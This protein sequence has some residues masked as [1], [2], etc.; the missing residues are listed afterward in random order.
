MCFSPK[1]M[2]FCYRILAPKVLGV[3]TKTRLESRMKKFK[4][5]AI[6]DCL[7]V[8][9]LQD[10]IGTPAYLEDDLVGMKVVKNEDED[11]EAD[12]TLKTPQ[13]SRSMFGG[14]SMQEPKEKEN[15]FGGSGG[16]GG[17]HI[18]IDADKPQ[19]NIFDSS[20]VDDV[21]SCSQ[22]KATKPEPEP[23]KPRKKKQ[24]KPKERVL[25][26]LP[27]GHMG[28]FQKEDEAD[29]KAGHVVA[30]VRPES[31]D[32][33][34]SRSGR[35]AVRDIF[36]GMQDKNLAPQVH[37]VQWKDKSQSYLPATSF[38]RTP[39]QCTMIDGVM[40][41]RYVNEGGRNFHKIAV[42][43][44]PSFTAKARQELVEKCT[45]MQNNPQQHDKDYVE[46]DCGTR[47]TAT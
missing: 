5:H 37:L 6:C 27:M 11:S 41:V 44:I 39:W 15:L 22:A 47:A 10:V 26:T 8:R 28:S 2:C 18:N 29:P 17:C 45:Q 32:D 3:S 38:R 13:G 31:L 12:C 9:V 36:K 1:E 35:K 46:V 7:H 33:V 4:L 21:G 25:P 19:K 14:D 34:R 24:R 30:I 40:Y 20:S 16:G 42:E 43:D 23:P